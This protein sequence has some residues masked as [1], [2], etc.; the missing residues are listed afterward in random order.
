[1]NIYQCWKGVHS[2][3]QMKDRELS[4]GVF[5]KHKPCST[6]DI[7][8]DSRLYWE[9][10]KWKLSF[11]ILHVI[12]FSSFSV[13]SEVKQPHI[14]WILLRSLCLSLW[15]HF[16]QHHEKLRCCENYSLCSFLTKREGE[17]RKTPTPLPVPHVHPHLL[18]PLFPSHIAKRRVHV[19]LSA[20]DA[21]PLRGWDLTK[22]VSCC[23]CLMLVESL[24]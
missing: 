8:A 21:A 23:R 15:I 16:T 11:N 6:A 9:R 22:H 1:M 19:R 3:L 24:M 14:R 4:L 17:R 18:S 13:L 10:I 12:T 2:I 20:A 7:P 5:F